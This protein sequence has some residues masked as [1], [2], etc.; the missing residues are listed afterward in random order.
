[1]RDYA[2]LSET[3]KPLLVSGILIAL[4]NRAFSLSFRDYKQKDL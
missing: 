1:M 4:R 3:E 2:K